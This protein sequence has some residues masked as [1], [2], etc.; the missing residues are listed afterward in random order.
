MYSK[1]KTPRRTVISKRGHLTW[2]SEDMDSLA[3]DID[4]ASTPKKRRLSRMN[5]QEEMTVQ[6][7]KDNREGQKQQ[8]LQPLWSY[9]NAQKWVFDIGR[10]LVSVFP[11]KRWSHTMCLSDPDTAVLIGGET[12]DQNYCED[13][14][15]K[16]ELGQ[17]S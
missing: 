7:K 17:R 12:E 8:T 16:L 11:S 6:I 4:Q 1:V 10:G 14:L 9:L 15:W 3:E 5:S 13:S 2:S